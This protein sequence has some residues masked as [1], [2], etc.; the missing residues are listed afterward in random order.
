MSTSHRPSCFTRW[1]SL[2]RPLLFMLLGSSGAAA[3]DAPT[4]VSGRLTIAA[5][6]SIA[7][8]TAALN[9]AFLRLHPDAEITITVSA[10]A[11]LGRQIGD[12]RAAIDLLLADDA[13]L[14]A[15]LIAAGAVDA[16]SLQAIG[17]GLLALWTNTPGVNPGRGR[18]VF[19][20]DYINRIAIADPASSPFGVIATTALERLGVAEIAAPKLQR[21][22]DDA[23]V[24][25]EIRNRVSD[26]GMLPLPMVKAPGNRDIGIYIL[27]PIGVYEPAAYTAVLTQRGAGNELAKTWLAFLRS[28]TARA[29]LA[30]AGFEP[31]GDHAAR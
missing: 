3:A 1:R 13:A 24:A 21:L 5:V 8:V 23:L 16:A 11:A 17:D 14:P 29:L 12:G 30:E 9:T 27:L 7:P 4:S 18:P 20:A 15:R 28:D 31:P 10:S 6:P 26:L 2:I 19:A 22:A 25:E